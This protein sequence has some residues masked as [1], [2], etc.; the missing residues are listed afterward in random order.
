MEQDDPD[1]TFGPMNRGDVVKNFV[2]YA[3]IK[4]GSA[5][6]KKPT[7][8]QAF[9]VYVESIIVRDIQLVALPKQPDILQLRAEDSKKIVLVLP[10]E[11]RFFHHRPSLPWDASAVTA[12]GRVTHQHKL[13]LAA[14]ES[15]LAASLKVPPS[16]K[17]TARTEVAT[18][19]KIAQKEEAGKTFR[20]RPRPARK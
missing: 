10:R 13:R 19:R 15:Y 12:T 5:Y 6:Y 20:P 11:G 8:E 4:L 18:Q 1:T 3:P 17:K 14:D 16:K 2:P 7:S 9:P